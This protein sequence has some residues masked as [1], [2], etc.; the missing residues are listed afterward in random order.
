MF[1]QTQ[2][3]LEKCSSRLELPNNYLRNVGN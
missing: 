1:K 3:F 2:I